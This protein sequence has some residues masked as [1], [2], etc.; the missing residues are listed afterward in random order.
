MGTLANSEEPD[1]MQHNAAMHQGLHCL[2]SLI[3]TSFKDRHLS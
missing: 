1:G 2:F 3:R